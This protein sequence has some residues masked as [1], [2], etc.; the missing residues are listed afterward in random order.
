LQYLKENGVSTLAAHGASIGGSLATHAVKMAPQLFKAVI[1]DKTFDSA[2]HVAANLLNNIG[3]PQWLIP[4]AIVRGVVASAFPTGL[5][6]PGTDNGYTDGLNNID[7]VRGFNGEF[8]VIGGRADHL[9]GSGPQGH[10]GNYPSNFSAD[11]AAAYPNS[12]SSCRHVA[13]DTGHSG[14]CLE[15]NTESQ[16]IEQALAAL[17]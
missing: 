4:A 13:T 10:L 7:K 9:M 5:R 15:D 14:F 17:S 11:L 3:I 8:V 1:L 2:A 6:V 16:A 12:S